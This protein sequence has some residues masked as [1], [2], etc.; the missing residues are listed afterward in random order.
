MEHLHVRGV[1]GTS[2]DSPDRKHLALRFV[3]QVQ[4]D[5]EPV[6]HGF[7]GTSVRDHSTL[8]KLPL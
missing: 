3:A 8:R 7:R 6:R 1:D 5:R 2:A 4:L